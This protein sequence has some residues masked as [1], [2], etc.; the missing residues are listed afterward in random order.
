[1]PLT[2]SNLRRLAAVVAALATLAYAGVKPG[3]T[4]FIKARNT[5][6]M[7]SPAANAQV[8]G[9]LQPGAP[10][11]WE[12]PDPKDKRWHRIT[13]GKVKGVVMGANLS[14][15]RPVKEVTS[16]KGA[17]ASDLQ[18]FMSSGAASKA[19]GTGALEYSKRE[20]AVEAATQ[21]QRVEQLAK[22]VGPQ[23]VS[24][25]ARKAGIVDAVGEASSVAEVKP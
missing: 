15:E 20:N 21:L 3:G 11:V 14:V 19:L 4:L 13:A 23:E 24:Q 6:V 1:M 7:Q 12:G 18:V 8:V 25:H 16:T 9:V 17:D 2:L 5:R 10:V 22:S